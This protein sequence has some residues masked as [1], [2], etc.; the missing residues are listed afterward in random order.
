METAV[1]SQSGSMISSGLSSEV[2]GSAQ[3]EVDNNKL[4]TYQRVRFKYQSC[5]TMMTWVVGG[6]CM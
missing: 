1:Q 4:L 2:I 6:S 3:C 5:Y